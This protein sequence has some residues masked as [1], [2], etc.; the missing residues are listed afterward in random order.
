MKP[1]DSGNPKMTIKNP[2]E[3]EMNWNQVQGAWKQ[4]RG[5]VKAQW[6]KLT[7][8]ELNQIA[9]K[10][11][12]LI[13]KIHKEIRNLAKRKP[14]SRLRTGRRPTVEGTEKKIKASGFGPV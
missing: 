13:G 14:K 5:K 8:E 7:D 9:G 12:I 11:D 10:R 4:I 3:K 1:C 2:K 6:G